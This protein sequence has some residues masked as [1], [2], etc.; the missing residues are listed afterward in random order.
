M[1]SYEQEWKLAR[2]DLRAALRGFRWIGH[3]RGQADTLHHLGVLELAAGRPAVA[4]GLLR[5]ALS[6]WQEV[7]DAGNS[8][9]SCAWLSLALLKSGEHDQA[10]AV[11]GTAMDQLSAEGY[12][13][14]YP[15]QEVWWA[16]YQ[17]LEAQGEEER[18]FQALEQAHR[19]VMEQAARID[20]PARRQSFLARI[21]V[22]HEIVARWRL[23]VGD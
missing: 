5:K 22:N 19:L 12:G 7:G 2:D 6:L 23:E 4:A 8:V 18:T 20:D 9:A 16:A 1:S 3:H 17:V 11:L 21:P 10:R 13:G 14:V 15:Q